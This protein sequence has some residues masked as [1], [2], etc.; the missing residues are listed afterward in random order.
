MKLSILGEMGV[1]VLVFAFDDGKHRN[2]RIH[3]T[4]LP[5]TM[6]YIPGALLRNCQA[7]TPTAWEEIVH[8]GCIDPIIHDRCLLGSNLRESP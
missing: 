7:Q 8:E 3:Y 4:P 1:A 5:A 2:P 6:L